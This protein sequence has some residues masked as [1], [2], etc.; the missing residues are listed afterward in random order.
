MGGGS[1]PPYPYA[2]KIPAQSVKISWASKKAPQ[3]RFFT[4]YLKESALRLFSS[5]PGRSAGKFFWGSWG[6]WSRPP[7]V[8]RGKGGGV[9][10]LLPGWGW[11]DPPPS[12][13]HKTTLK[14]LPEV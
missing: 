10:P 5:F 13:L 11:S 2:K 6:D 3:N 4:H 14:T 7:Q 1:V 9:D 12:L 8:R